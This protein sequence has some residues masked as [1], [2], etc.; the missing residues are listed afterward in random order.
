MSK[1]RNSRAAG[2]VYGLWTI[3][4]KD[5]SST[6]KHP[7]YICQC[8]CGTLASVWGSGLSAIGPKAS[9]SCGCN[10]VKSARRT[11]GQASFVM[12]F[13]RYI[14]NAEFRGLPFLLTFQDFKVLC[15]QDCH[16]CGALPQRYN[17][18]IRKDGTLS[19]TRTQAA[20]DR[21]WIEVNGIDRK[22]SNL[23]Y[24]KANCVPACS[25]CNYSKLDY[26]YAE[27]L[28]H[29]YRVV[30]H[31]QKIKEANGEVQDNQDP[32]RTRSA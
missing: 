27:F 22:D 32:N 18:Y 19:P 12:L 26:S 15:E 5:P 28:N 4:S 16:Y 7:K 24:D 8:A 20:A 25:Q 6:V 14:K 17:T 29:C 31:Q 21:A 13:N 23:P 9:R 1:K 10:Q 11:P 30:A 2:A 3:I